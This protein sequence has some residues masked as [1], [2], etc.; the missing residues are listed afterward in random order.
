MTGVPHCCWWGRSFG[1][2]PRRK[3]T[4]KYKLRSLEKADAY[5]ETEQISALL[6]CEEL[7]SGYKSFLLH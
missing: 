3:Y 4:V 5:T 7:Y 6:C 2:K 1:L